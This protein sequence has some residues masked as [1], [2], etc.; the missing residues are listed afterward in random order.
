VRT[1]L[2]TIWGAQCRGCG[3]AIDPAVE[4]RKQAIRVL[5]AKHEEHHGSGRVDLDHWN[6]CLQTWELYEIRVTPP[7]GEKVHRPFKR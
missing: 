2:Q 6:G 3:L 4:G 5:R 7:V 1:G